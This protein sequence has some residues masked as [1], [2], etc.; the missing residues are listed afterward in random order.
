MGPSNEQIIT[1]RATAIL[2]NSDATADVT[3]RLLS[4][5][6]FKPVD[7]EKFWVVSPYYVNLA[8]CYH[9]LGHTAKAYECL[10]EASKL[11]DTK[12][13]PSIEPSEK[14]YQMGRLI[15][16]AAHVWKNMQD[17]LRESQ[18]E[19]ETHIEN[20]TVKSALLAKQAHLFS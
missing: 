15:V 17:L 20:W 10:A 4:S 18:L 8:C 7:T 16:C 12:F 13:L 6:N 14:R 5:V 3:L 19:P 11:I 2:R 9:K 1:A